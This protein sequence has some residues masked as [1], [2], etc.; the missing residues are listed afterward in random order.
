MVEKSSL[1]RVIEGLHGSNILQ[2]MPVK[3]VDSGVEE[4]GMEPRGIG[5]GNFTPM[6]G[7]VNYIPKVQLQITL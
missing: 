5:W 1:L 4:N 7:L 2:N 6:M 3:K